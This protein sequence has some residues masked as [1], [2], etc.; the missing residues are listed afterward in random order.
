MSFSREENL[1]QLSLMDGTL[2]PTILDSH[3]GSGVSQ[4]CNLRQTTSLLHTQC[5]HLKNNTFLAK[6]FQGLPYRGDS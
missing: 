3:P 1:R 5:P 6:L 4:V 2:G